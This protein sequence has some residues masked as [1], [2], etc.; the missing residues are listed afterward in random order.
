MARQIVIVGGGIVGSALAECLAQ[1]DGHSVTVLERA[2]RERLQGSTGHAPGFIGL[3]NEAPVLTELARASALR[4]EGLRH[5]GWNGFDRSGGLEVATTQSA[6]SSLESRAAL[7]AESGIP[8]RLLTADQTVRSA[9]DLINPRHCLG[10]LFY[11]HD[12]TARADV[13]TSALQLRAAEA[14]ATFVHDAE[15]VGFEAHGNHV[16]LV[17]TQDRSY[18]ADDVVLACGIWGAGVAELI[19]MHL[20]LTPVAHPYVYGP[21]RLPASTVSPFVR[22]PEH[23]VYARDHGDRYG[24]GTYDHAP[25]PV[26]YESLGHVAEQPWDANNFDRALAQALDLLPVTHRFE[27]EHRLNGVFSMTADNLPLLGPTKNLAG[28]WIAEAIWVTH[29]AGAAAALTR[30]MTGAEPRALGLDS[31]NPDRFNGQQ[32][33]VLRDQALKLYRDIYASTP[34]GSNG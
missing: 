24:L 31:L 32:P 20:P 30:L 25:V 22:W 17:R 19:G 7:A 34:P 11:P 15:V 14:G 27:P 6:L 18:R 21:T 16:N 23:H 1:V 8:V 33:E 9:P 2:P 13:L 10:G 28:L 5:N 26:A 3:L 4:Y 29:A 12:G